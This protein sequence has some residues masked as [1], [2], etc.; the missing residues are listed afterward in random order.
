MLILPLLLI[1][2]LFRYQEFSE[3]QHRRVPL[4]SGSVLW[5]TIISTIKRDITLRS[6]NFFNTRNRSKTKGFPYEFY[7]HF[8]T[9][10]F[11]RKISIFLPHPFLFIIFFATRNFLKQSQN[12][13]STKCFGSVRQKNFRRNVVT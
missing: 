7:R 11:R 2:K 9:I 1:H 4:R 8:D 12:G 5:S 10:N 6:I 13:S 3:T